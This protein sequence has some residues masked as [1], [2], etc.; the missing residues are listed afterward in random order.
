MKECRVETRATDGQE[1]MRGLASHAL[2]MGRTHQR[3]HL[4][5]DRSIE[6][7]EPGSTDKEYTPT[8]AVPVCILTNIAPAPSAILRGL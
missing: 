5:L 8:P 1:G 6:L 4:L 3:A 2:K 7:T